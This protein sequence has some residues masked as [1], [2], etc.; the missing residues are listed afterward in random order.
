MFK[1]ILLSLT[2]LAAF[3]LAGI[4]LTNSA[5]AWRG[6]VG[7]PYGAYYAPRYYSR[8]YPYRSFYGPRI[9]RPYYSSYYA[10]PAY[11]VYPY[12]NYYYYGPGSGVSVSFGF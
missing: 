6:W 9:Y 10:Y 4:G 12:P 7:R 8:G 2:F 11:P 1:R 5:N 3:N